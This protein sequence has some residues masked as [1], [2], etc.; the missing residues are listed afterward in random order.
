VLGPGAAGA[1]RGAPPPS[2][3][4]LAGAGAPVSRAFSEPALQA[5]FASL[6]PSLR[7]HVDAPGAGGQAWLGLTPGWERLDLST[8][9]RLDLAAPDAA[10]QAEEARLINALRPISRTPLAEMPGFSLAGQGDDARR[11]LTCLTQAV[12]YEAAREPELGQAAV[13]QVV[14][15]RL[16]H[17]G[18]PKSV[19]GVVYQGSA[20]ATGCQFTFT[21]DGSLSRA[22]DPGLWTRAEAVARRALSGHVVREVGSATHY[23]ADYVA[24][25]W[26]PTLVKLAQIGAHIFYRWTGPSGERGAFSGRYAGGEAYLAPAVLG[27]VDPR[28]QVGLDAVAPPPP[29]TVTLALAGETRTYT[30]NEPDAV[31]SPALPAPGQLSPARRRPT[32]E[33][34]R[35]I[36]AA[37]AAIE[38]GEAAPATEAGVQP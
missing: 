15:N 33:E 12:Y 24:P 30:V 21:C 17:P 14:L 19:C 34:I 8:P 38:R 7:A 26:A 9:P 20:R 13:A 18:Y 5:R 32:A 35:S 1:G 6:S 10:A 36:N 25:Y 11:A 2:A 3:A 28:T 37:L 31:G 23:H 29:R 22:P 27:G 4:G 16:R